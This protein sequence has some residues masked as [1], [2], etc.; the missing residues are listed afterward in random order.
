M[1]Q[2]FFNN[3]QFPGTIGAIDCSHV[4]ILKPIIESHNFLNRKGYYS[5]NVQLICDSNL[6]FLNI[7]TNY[8]GSMHDSF[9][10]S[11]SN[12]KE[13]LTQQ[14]NMGEQMWLIGD[15]GYPLQPFLMT[16]VSNAGEGTPEQRYNTRHAAARNCIERAIGVLKMRFR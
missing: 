1:K 9:I 11:Q 16:P 15:S 8:P 6:M 2:S 7:N 12:I 13:Y 10:W 14:F 4:A 3:Y 5:L